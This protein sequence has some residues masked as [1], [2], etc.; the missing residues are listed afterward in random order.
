MDDGRHQSSNILPVVRFDDGSDSFDALQVSVHEGIYPSIFTE[1][2]LESILL[3]DA[4]EAT[5]I[6]T[7]Q[8]Q[9]TKT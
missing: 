9:G 8:L 6:R 3:C 2:S 7:K 5:N 4:S 1:S